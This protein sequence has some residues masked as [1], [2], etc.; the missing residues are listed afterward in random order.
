MAG[1]TRKEEAQDNQ[2]KITKDQERSLEE[3]MEELN[4]VLEQL[5][6]GENT[7]EESFAQYQKGMELVKSAGQKLDQVE[8]KILVLKEDD[9]YGEL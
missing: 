5:E 7:L 4:N 3:M 9:T 1:R 8:K 2:E 6:N